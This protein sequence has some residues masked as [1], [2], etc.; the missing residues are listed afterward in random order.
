[1]DSVVSVWIC[2][3]CTL[4]RRISVCTPVLRTASPVIFV[5]NWTP[6]PSH[7]EMCMHTRCPRPTIRQ[8]VMSDSGCE[9]KEEKKNKKQKKTYV[10][11]IPVLG[12]RRDP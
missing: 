1:M 3:Y 5:Q 12:N 7:L 10:I 11:Y 9:S 8:L 4:Q 2:R 6:H